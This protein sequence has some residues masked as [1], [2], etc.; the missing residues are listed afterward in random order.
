MPA[1]KLTKA[2]KASKKKAAEPLATY[3]AKRDFGITP[4][5]SPEVALPDSDQPRFV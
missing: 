3:R 5:P 1:K 4:E 2:K